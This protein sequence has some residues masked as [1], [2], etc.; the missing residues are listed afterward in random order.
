MKSVKVF[1]IQAVSRIEY[2]TLVNVS[3]RRSLLLSGKLV[4]QAHFINT[5]CLRDES[6]TRCPLFLHK[7]SM[8]N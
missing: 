5:L 1:A 8:L 3:F 4:G 7:V 6:H 2:V